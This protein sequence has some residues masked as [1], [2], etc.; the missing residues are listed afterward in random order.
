[1]DPRVRLW[2][3][4]F[5]WA[6]GREPP[7]PRDLAPFV[8]QVLPLAVV[9]LPQLSVAEVVAWLA[10]R[11]VVLPSLG[12]DRPLRGCLV[13]WRGRGLLLV[14]GTDSPE[15]RRFTVAHEVAH[16]LLEHLLP[17]ERAVRYLGHAVQE[18]LDGFRPPIP[19]ERLEALLMGVPLRPALHRMDRPGCPEA[20]HAECQ[21]DALA[22]ELLAPARWVRAFLPRGLRF[23]EGEKTVRRVLEG[24][25]GLPLG[26]AR[27]Y[28]RRL[29]ERWA[30]GPSLRE[31]LGL[32]SSP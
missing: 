6:V 17:R 26:P 10:R 29:L 16:F 25:F 3:R 14:D 32:H 15:E 9:Y 12:P 31:W 11:R 21:A 5:W 4:R 7:P 27:W 18:V 24:T 28:A 22:L 8:P 2:S 30:G 19:E 13:A 23:I 1:M 20:F